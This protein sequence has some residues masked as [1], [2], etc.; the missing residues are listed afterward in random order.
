MGRTLLAALGSL[1]IY[2]ATSFWGDFNAMVAAEGA[3]EAGFRAEEI[4]EVVSLL[5]TQD[6]SELEALWGVGLF[7]G[8][9]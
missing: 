3:R 9:L 6:N 4:S 2:G 8:L 7:V 5:S 1:S